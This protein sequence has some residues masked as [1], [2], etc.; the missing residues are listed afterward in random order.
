VSPRR[1]GHTL[2]DLSCTTGWRLVISAST[3]TTGSGAR[4]GLRGPTAAVVVAL[5]F[6]VTMLCATLPT[7]LYPIYEQELGFGGVMVTLIFAAYAVG[8]AAALVLFGRLS[9][10]IGRR[11]VLL[12]GVALAVISSAVFLIPDNIPTLFVGR[13]LS[14]LSAGIFTG[15]ATATIAELAPKGRHQLYSLLAAVVNM[16]GLGLGPVLSGALA[17]YAPAPLYLSYAVHIVLMLVTGAVLLAIAEP[18]TPSEGPVSWRPQQVSVP[19][20]VRGVFIRAAIAGFAGFAVLGLFT[21]VSPTFVGQILHISNH[22]VTGLV[23]F[24]LLGPSALGQIAS[25]R[26]GER[27]ALLVGCVGLVIGVLVV[28]LSV[29]MA[30]LWLLVAGAVVAGVGQGMSFRA[31]LGAVSAGSP[32]ERRSEVASS[33]F[34]VLYVAISLPVIG[35]GLAAAAFGLVPAAVTFSVIVAVLAAIAFVSLLRRPENG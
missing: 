27:P 28:G 13:V 18:I 6:P 4:Q 2:G 29:A 35:E 33:F 16:L 17:Q 7:P 8:V 23:V 21:A 32:P 30:S 5:V 24:S 14:G 9:D 25:S 15:T 34:L 11:K 19:P 1:S 31:G 3:D 26:L 22:L 20:E 12:P 10:Q